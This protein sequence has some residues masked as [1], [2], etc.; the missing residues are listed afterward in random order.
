MSVIMYRL[1]GNGRAA[2][3]LQDGFL[4]GIDLTERD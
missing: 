1:K 3:I 2:V 4:F